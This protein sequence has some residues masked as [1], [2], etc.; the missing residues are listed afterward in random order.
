M[1]SDVSAMSDSDVGDSR[2]SLRCLQ[3][4]RISLTFHLSPHAVDIQSTNVF[5]CLPLAR[6]LFNHPGQCNGFQL[7]RS[8]NMTHKPDL[9]ANN[10]L[11]EIPWRV[12]FE[13]RAK[14]EDYNKQS[15][16]LSTARSKISKMRGKVSEM[17]SLQVL[18]QLNFRLQKIGSKW[19]GRD[20]T[21]YSG[22]AFRTR[23][24]ASDQSLRIERHVQRTP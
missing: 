22:R 11:Q 12:G 14:R 21:L 18:Q 4:F 24:P 1:P 9:P 10:H 8:H 16:G 20:D 7:I 5:L 17:T 13:D 15:I 2:C 3:I 19:V 23:G 6:L